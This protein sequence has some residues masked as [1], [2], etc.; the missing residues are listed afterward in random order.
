MASSEKKRKREENEEA[1]ERYDLSDEQLQEIVRMVCANNV[2]VEVPP[3][4]FNLHSVRV[5]R[6]FN[7]NE[8]VYEINIG[9][10]NMDTLPEFL[11]NLRRVFQS[12]INL[13]RYNAN[14]DKDKA[15]FYISR[16]PKTP[17]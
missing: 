13:M 17:F 5:N 3:T 4:V 12:L 14:S 1:E 11:N 9:H 10:N 2:I 6:R 16:A 8:Y 7:N 15:R